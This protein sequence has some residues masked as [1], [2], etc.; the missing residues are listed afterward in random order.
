MKTTISKNEE[1]KELKKQLSTAMRE[2]L[3][4]SRAIVKV[5]SAGRECQQSRRTG[6]ATGQ[7]RAKNEN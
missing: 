4:L 6:T 2:V 1:L 3:R 7:N 5:E